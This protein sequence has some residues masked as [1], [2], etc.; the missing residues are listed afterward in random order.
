M[1]HGVNTAGYLGVLVSTSDT[2]GNSFN[3]FMTQVAGNVTFSPRG[4]GADIVLTAVPIF[5]IIPIATDKIKATGTT[6]T[7]IIGLR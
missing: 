5:T 4:G 2:L 6:S 1:E 3:A 7:G